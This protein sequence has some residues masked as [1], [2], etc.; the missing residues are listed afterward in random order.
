RCSTPCS[1][2]RR[3]SS[4]RRRRRRRP[5]LELRR[6]LGRRRRQRSRKQLAKGPP[7]GGPFS[8]S[9]FSASRF[10][11]FCPLARAFGPRH[12]L[13]AR[14]DVLIQMEH[15]PRVVLV[16]QRDQPLVV[17]VAV[18]RADPLVTGVA[19]EVEVHPS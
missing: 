19:R 15:V 16:L 9:C 3:S 8:A 13:G 14:P 10:S 18:G 11:A 2:P 7:A 4:T 6:L 17:L 1:A 12:G 5:R